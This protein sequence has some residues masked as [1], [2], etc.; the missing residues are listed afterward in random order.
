MITQGAY[1]GDQ[2]ASLPVLDMGSESGNETLTFSTMARELFIVNDDTAD[3]SF[4][5]TDQ[6]GKTYSFTLKSCESLDDRFVPF[7]KVVVTSS[8]AW[9][10][11]AKS[12]R[13]T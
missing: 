3:L 11:I 5:L 4:V 10:W 8:G 6:D 12:G 1:H 9:R 2:R 7:A 13:I